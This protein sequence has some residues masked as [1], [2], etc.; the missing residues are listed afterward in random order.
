MKCKDKS[1]SNACGCVSCF[2]NIVVDLTKADNPDSE[3]CKEKDKAALSKNADTDRR[4]NAIVPMADFWY[5]YAS[6]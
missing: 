3:I 6:K 5:R 1:N 2:G 4:F